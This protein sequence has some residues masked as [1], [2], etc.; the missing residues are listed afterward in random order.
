[1]S[2]SKIHNKMNNKKIILRERKMTDLSFV[3]N[4]CVWLNQKKMNEGDELWQW[5]HQKYGISQILHKLQK[6]CGKK[7]LIPCY[8]WLYLIKVTKKIIIVIK[9]EIE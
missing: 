1:M 6:N 2:A 8:H 3:L 4:Y 9:Y 7:M 5:V